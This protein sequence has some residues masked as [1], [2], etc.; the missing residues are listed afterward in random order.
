M[1][2]STFRPRFFL[3]RLQDLS[4]QRKNPDGPWLSEAATLLLDNWLKPS[5]RGFEWG[6]GCSTTWLARRVSRL[7]SVEDNPAWYE[8]VRQ[9]LAGAG[10]AGKVDYRLIECGFTEQSE[11]EAHPYAGAIEEFPDEHFDFALIDGNVR[12]LC[13]RKALAKLRP[14]GLLILDNANRY[15]PNPFQGGHSTVHEPCT[16]P[17]SAGWGELIEALAPWRWVNTTNG[18]WDT[19]FW[20]KPC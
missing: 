16:A 13:M 20:V 1:R 9:M 12:L 14:G 4:F 15:V 17:R 8:R 18:I 10:V 2:L 19:R 3:R 11:P 5:D 7:V 6:S